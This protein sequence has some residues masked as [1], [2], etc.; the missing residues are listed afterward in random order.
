MV[1]WSRADTELIQE[2][3]QLHDRATLGITPCDCLCIDVLRANRSDSMINN[4][5]PYFTQNEG[6]FSSNASRLI[7]ETRT[8]TTKTQPNSQWRKYIFRYPIQTISL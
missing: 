1:E 5:L 7:E 6:D 2:L 8:K 4:I 3:S